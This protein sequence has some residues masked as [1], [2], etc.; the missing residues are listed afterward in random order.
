MENK[1]KMNMHCNLSFD[2]MIIL[3][4]IIVRMVYRALRKKNINV[5]VRRNGKQMITGPNNCL[6]PTFIYISVVGG[7][8]IVSVYL[9]VPFL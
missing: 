4:V 6:R 8:F 9:F 5:H 1:K 3:L 7:I 2:D